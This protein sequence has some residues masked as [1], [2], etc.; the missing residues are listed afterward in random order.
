MVRAE[1]QAKEYCAKQ[2]LQP[3]ILDRELTQNI[4]TGDVATL[5]LHCIDPQDIVHTTD[6]FGVDLLSSRNINGV[7]ILKVTR[8]TIGAKAGVAADDVVY[9]YAGR[10]IGSA[11]ELKSS[12]AD[13]M[14]GQQV[15]MKLRR[16]N[17]DITVTAQF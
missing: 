9:E 14:P 17:Q 3:F 13:T 11:N 1:T 6:A 15:V 8:G 10:P 12:V 4:W 7:M 2:G 5:K 16:A